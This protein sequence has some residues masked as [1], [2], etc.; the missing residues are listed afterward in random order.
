MRPR[1]KRR[2]PP[3]RPH[4]VPPPLTLETES[5]DGMQVL[6]ESPNDLGLLLWQTIR[7]VELWAALP[8]AERPEAFAAGAYGERVSSIRTWDLPVEVVEPLAAAASVLRGADAGKVVTAMR[9]LAGWAEGAE[10]PGTALAAMR[11][12]A[13]CAPA[14]AELAFET[15]RLAWANQ[16]RPLAEMWFR[17]A[18]T[19]SR[20]AGDRATLARSYLALTHVMVDRGS[21]PLARKMAIRAVRVAERHSLQELRGP[22]HHGM[23]AIAVTE[24]DQRAAVHHARLAMRHY[25]PGHPRLPMLALDLAYGWMLRGYF[26]VAADVFGALTAH[27]HRP[28]ERMFLFANLARAAAGSGDLPRFEEAAAEVRVLAEA[29]GNRRWEVDALLE[30]AHGELLLARYEAAGPLL[31]QVREGAEAAAKHQVRHQAEAL[32]QALASERAAEEFRQRHRRRTAPRQISA[33]A[34]DLADALPAGAPA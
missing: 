10:R 21:A 22:A 15:G 12:A 11:A 6:R 26:A 1:A 29:P 17:Q 24:G 7:A 3:K 18:L 34:G 5:L 33:L 13:K 32:L 9:E 20:R 2:T 25:D 28:R 27:V 19:L 14:D 30:V 23:A 31:E 8:E 4:R 16:Q